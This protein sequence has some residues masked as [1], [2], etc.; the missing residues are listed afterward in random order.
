MRMRS[1]I[2]TSVGMSPKSA[3]IYM[4]TLGSGTASVQDIARKIDMKRPTVYLYV[5]ELLRQGFLE[6]VPYNKKQYYKAISPEV[7]E[8]RLEKN[9]SEFRRALPELTSL[10]SNNPRGPKVR[11]LE[12]KAAL[13]SAYEETINC[14]SLRVW[15][16]IGKVHPL[17]HETYTK[18][19]EAIREKGI[20][21]R[22]IIADNKDS[23][24]YSRTIGHIAGPTYSSRIATAEGITNDTLIYNDVVAVFRLHEFNM[25]VVRIEDKTIADS[26]R[27]IFEMSWKSATP[28]RLAST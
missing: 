7:L 4:A 14:L 17:F 23:R 1:D 9:I 13:E 19:M 15:S 18:M 5:E 2:L 8:R 20:T 22:E 10:Y 12:G 28:L 6:R 11:M 21:A 25:F 26:M 24:R 3:K 16:N 27:A